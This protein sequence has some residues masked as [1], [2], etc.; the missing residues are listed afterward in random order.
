MLFNIPVFASAAIILLSPIVSAWPRPGAIIEPRQDTNQT[1]PEEI[2]TP[3]PNPPHPSVC[4]A[5]P[6]PF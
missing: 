6:I 1:S 3:A 5:Y 4:Y 2:G